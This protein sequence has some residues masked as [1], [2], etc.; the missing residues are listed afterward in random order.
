MQIALLF[1]GQGA[2]HE[3]MAA[4]LYGTEP[5]FTSVLDAVFDRFGPEGARI[6]EDWLAPHPRVDLDDVRRAQPLLFAIEY[7]LG[8]MLIAGG[9]RPAAVLGHSV[10]EVVGAT[11]AGVFH[12]DQAI[13]LMRDRITRIT[14]AG[15]GG[16]V[17]VAASAEQLAPYLRGEVV[18]G[19][20]NAPRQTVL[21]G[22][23]PELSTVEAAVVAGGFIA[24]RTRALAPFHSPALLPMCQPSWRTPVR[25]SAPR[26]TVYSCYT[27]DVLTDAQAVDDEYWAIQP[28]APVRFWPAA[29]RLLNDGPFVVVEAGPGQGLT[30]LLRR[31]KTVVAGTNV[32]QPLLPDRPGTPADD[33]QAVARL[34]D[35]LS[36]AGSF[37]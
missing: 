32:L 13:D 17:A 35:S 30:S 37:V 21:A 11:L 31:H 8:R 34:W 10:G 9:V 14:G 1:P 20:I 28:A 24:R 7:A 6:R 25:L 2:Q 15:P 4:G 36:R 12:L 22:P 26:L 5:T 23:E 19:A 29:D 33:R 18:V 16:M 27:G 3:R